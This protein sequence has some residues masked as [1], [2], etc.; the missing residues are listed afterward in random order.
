MTDG[1]RNTV[2]AFDRL[3]PGFQS[4]SSITAFAVDVMNDDDNEDDDELANDE[5][6]GVSI[7]CEPSE[8]YLP[9][10]RPRD[11]SVLW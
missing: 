7:R 10:S 5:T 11:C 2:K 6:G 8:F 1:V 3:C 4:L 9:Y